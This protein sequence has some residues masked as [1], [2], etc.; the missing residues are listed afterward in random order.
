MQWKKGVTVRYFESSCCILVY[1]AYI[2]LLIVDNAAGIRD[3]IIQ[4]NEFINS[5]TGKS[6]LLKGAN[7]V[8]K[9]PPWLP[10]V[11]GSAICDTTISS[12]KSTSCQTFNKYDAQHLKDEGYNFIRLGVI[13]AGAQPEDKNSLSDSYL[14]RL[15][16]IL[17][18]AHEFKIAV[19]LDVHQDA[20]G[21]A[22]CGEGLPMWFSATK[23]IPNEIGK[24]LYPLPPL[25]DKSCGVND[26]EA[27]LQYAGDPD[28]NI[29]NE[30]CRKYNSGNWYELTLTM[31]AENSLKYLF[32]QEGGEYYANFMKL[33]AEAVDNYPAAIGIELMNEPPQINDRGSMYELWHKCYLKIR[34]VSDDLAVAIMDSAEIAVV[35][36]TNLTKATLEWLENDAHYVFYAFHWYGYPK[37]VTD[38]I[39]NAKVVSKNWN[40]P[41]LL[42]EFGGYGGPDYGC[43]TQNNATNMGVGSAYWHY[44]DYCWPKHCPNGL[45][46]GYCPLP[47]G[48]RWG[49]CITGWGS[50]NSSFRC[51]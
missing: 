11:S 34:E 19:L 36:N 37:L 7:I 33:L 35:D 49:A 2:F 45:P 10:S 4:N 25:K 39:K 32:S 40:M 6:L 38:G 20:I 5:Y 41:T 15:Y 3:V 22:V 29:K 43:A 1:V 14:K 44:S 21:T 47:V 30:C 26:T 18:L 46:D 51:T 8:M 24:P 17:N 42:T 9:G 28:Y 23:A 48:N 16:D 12:G 13:W 31:Q 27:W 50:G